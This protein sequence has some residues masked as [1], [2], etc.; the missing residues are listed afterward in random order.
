MKY[1]SSTIKSKWIK[2]SW[3]L[4]QPNLRK[5]VP[6]T[7][8][9]NKKNLI[10][11][12]DEFSTV[13]FK[14]TGG[15]GGVNIIRIKRKKNGYE[16]QYHSV[17]TYY[18]TLGQLYGKLQRFSK[19]K[20]FLLQKGINLA[21]TNG[22]PF[23]LRVM[24]QKTNKGDW[25]S[26]AIFAKIGNP[27]KVAT[28]YNQ[29]GKIGYIDETLSGAGYNKASIRQMKKVLEQLGVSVGR[30]FERHSKGM[31]ELGL[32]VA[33]DAKREQWILEVNT[34]PQF[35]PLKNMKNKKL[36]RRIV[37]YAK[38]YGRNK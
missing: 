11:M 27:G 32:D 16:I 17:K 1:R 34:R 21:R 15:S 18:P 33:L 38:Q 9:F 19:K 12:L 2:N 7:M 13:I 36:Y 31:R 37:S 4:K 3:L 35:Y 28:N 30:N 23:D 22:N 20:S 8:L 25:K 5:H 14:P 24:V 10:T 26:T 6:Q 29:G